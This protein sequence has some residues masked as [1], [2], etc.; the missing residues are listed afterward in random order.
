MGYGTSLGTAHEDEISYVMDA[1]AR[2][3]KQRSDQA[4]MNVNETSGDFQSRF[5]AVEDNNRPK[6]VIR[7]PS[8]DPTEL[9]DALKQTGATRAA[10]PEGLLE[11]GNINLFNRPKVKNEDGSIST[12]R[13]ISVGTDK[14]E[15]LIP[16]VHDDG[17]IMSNEE[18]I[19][20]YQMTGKHLG[21]FNSPDN[22]TNYAQSLHEA[23][24]KLYN[25]VRDSSKDIKVNPWV[26]I[27]P[28]DIETGINVGMGAGPASVENAGR[29][30]NYI[31]MFLKQG[32]HTPVV[33]PAAK[34]ASE[35]FEPLI[36]PA[37]GKPS[38]SFV[39]NPTTGEY[40]PIK[41]AAV[42]PLEQTPLFQTVRTAEQKEYPKD[43]LHPD[44][45]SSIHQNDLSLKQAQDL[46]NT[47]ADFKQGALSKT[48]YL[49]EMKEYELF[50][51][52]K[53]KGKSW[54]NI[55][56]TESGKKTLKDQYPWGEWSDVKGKIKE[57][58]LD[59][60]PMTHG[61]KL[62]DDLLDDY[63]NLL[64]SN[65]L[66]PKEKFIEAM[67]NINGQLKST[68]ANIRD[69]YINIVKE[70]KLEPKVTVPP[71]IAAKG[72][73][74]PAYRGLK[75]YGGKEVN[76]V[77]K[78]GEVVEGELY[79][80]SSP[81]LADMYTD[82][83]SKHPGYKVPEGAFKEGSQVMPLYINT[84]DYHYYNAK[85][86]HWTTANPEAITQALRAKK[87]GVIVD[88][89]RD[90]P[91]ST[92]HLQPKKI[93]ITFPSGAST[94]KS[95]F[96]KDFDPSSPNILHGIGSIAGAGTAAGYLTDEADRN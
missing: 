16:T 24:D 20:H 81:M 45:F 43:H 70:A 49:D 44:N 19:K 13:S 69:K 26:T 73:T 79:S 30:S 85:G 29:Y 7:T 55:P 87:K 86:G 91:N 18:A 56:I 52:N 34:G 5:G 83:L 27:T 38:E 21:I 12:V 48:E 37:T 47:F 22:A 39:H 57:F 17:Y 6:V 42:D 75:I 1:D 90:E 58:D 67:D 76:P 23:Q 62:L 78:F 10:E 4:E 14:G 68:F 77:Y 88:N 64:N 51:A 93:F 92:G 9:T 82:Y 36:V 84:K 65:K 2:T 71:E 32:D 61:K 46:H 25:P 89:V 94:V 11:D 74:E 41:Q 60:P 54:T 8:Q 59:N 40:K 28:E 15:A 35:G 72:Y 80:T 31:D 33:K 95:R 96:A 63:P 50:S 53:A 3:N 66:T